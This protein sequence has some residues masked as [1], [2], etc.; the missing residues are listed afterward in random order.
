MEALFEKER[1]A[2][3]ENDYEETQRIF[4]EMV[5]LCG[6]DEELLG[7][8]RILTIKRGQNRTAIKWLIGEMF[9]KKQREA[10][11]VDF[12]CSVLRDVIE[13]RI[14]LEEERIYITEE[15]KR[16]YESRGD[17]QD[18][19][20]VVIN[21]PVETFMMIK[22]NV[23]INYQLEQLRLCVL[24]SDWIRADITMKKIR[25]KYF[26]DIDAMDEKIKF[27]RMTVLL[28]LGQRKY[29]DACHVYCTLGEVSSDR[30]ENIVLSSF[31]CILATC[32]TEMSPISDKRMQM[33]YKLSEDKNNDET[34]RTIVNKFLSKL[35]LEKSIIDDVQRV[36]SPLLD[37]SIYLSDLSAAVD[38]HN[39]RI[40]EMFYSS[41]NI[42]DMAVIMQT[43]IE[44]VVRKISFMVNNGF[45]RCRID[46][47]TGMI[48]FEE[49]KW[50][51]DVASVMDKLIK[52]NHL[53]HKERLKGSL[54][55]VG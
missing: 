5:E 52:C 40:V 27:H 2:R 43:S 45:A 16:R 13:G 33:L 11:F 9:A 36:M 44:D 18:A 22:E 26:E 1:K 42:E 23:I 35:V 21:V 3:M 12:F 37:I 10:G 47:M 53:V 51:D 31:F 28:Y 54:K 30:T 34:M 6:S 24:S 15:L 7:L 25:K 29:F 14:F 4:S 17:L 39:F 20:E 41:V 38:E 32:E 50:N 8:I 49:R 48:K 46:Q 55:R 19:L